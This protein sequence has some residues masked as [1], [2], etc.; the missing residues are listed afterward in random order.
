MAADGND[1]CT[2][3]V[4]MLL[5]PHPK[6]FHPAFTWGYYTSPFSSSHDQG[7]SIRDDHLLCI[8]SRIVVGCRNVPHNQCYLPANLPLFGNPYSFSA[9]ATPSVM[10]S[11]RKLAPLESKSQVVL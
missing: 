10:M 3:T 2:S 4:K 6:A 11:L 7:S 8:Q 5:H 1:T 9:L